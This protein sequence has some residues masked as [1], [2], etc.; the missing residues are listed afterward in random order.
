MASDEWQS[1]P[2]SFSLH[3]PQPSDQ[4]GDRDLLVRNLNSRLLSFYLKPTWL[5]PFHFLSLPTRFSFF[6]PFFFWCSAFMPFLIS[7]KWLPT[8]QTPKGTTTTG[9]GTVP[10]RGLGSPSRGGAPLWTS[11]R[12]EREV[13]LDLAVL[14]AIPQSAHDLLILHVLPSKFPTKGGSQ[15]GGTLW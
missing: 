15:P 2:I 12:E 11:Q 4:M 8:I 10:L 13:T 3:F 14:D 7:L 9:M 5:K 1:C 6:P